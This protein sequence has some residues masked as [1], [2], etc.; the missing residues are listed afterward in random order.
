MRTLVIGCGSMGLLY[1]AYLAKAGYDVT[2]ACRTLEQA[3]SINSEG[4]IVEHEGKIEV[5]KVSATVSN[6][7]QR[8]QY[9]IVIVAVKAYHVPQ[10]AD[11]VVNAIPRQRDSLIV[12]V[13]NGLGSLEFLEQKFGKHTVAA[14]VT[15][16]GAYRLGLNRIVFVGGSGIKLGQR[17]TQSHLLEVFASMLRDGGLNVEIVKDVDAWRWDKLIVNAA[18]NPTTALLGVPNGYLL[19]SPHIVP[20]IECVVGEAVNVAERLK[21]KLPRD[22]FKAVWETIEATRANKSSML[23]DIESRRKTEIEYINGMIVKKGIEVGVPVP[24]NYMLY[25]LIK[26][27]EDMLGAKI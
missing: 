9:D 27:L 7:V 5:A 18:I 19:R 1:A 22:P 26:S 13:Q 11:V 17:D 2:V 16:Y 4:I 3:D 21:I 14:A 23:Q 24:C 8:G 12:S 25:N 15:Y 10:V 6:A 20:V